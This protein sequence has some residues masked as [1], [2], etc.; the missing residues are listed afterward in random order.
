MKFFISYIQFKSKIL[1]P[2]SFL[3]MDMKVLFLKNDF[4]HAPRSIVKH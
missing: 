3:A 2:T 4:F 1:F